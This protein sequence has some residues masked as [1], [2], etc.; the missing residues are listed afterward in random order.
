MPPLHLLL[1]TA[2]LAND[3]TSN[4][5]KCA[6]DNLG[7]IGYCENQERIPLTAVSVNEDTGVTIVSPVAETGNGMQSLDVWC[8]KNRPRLHNL[9]FSLGGVLL[10]GW[11]V[12]SVRQAEQLV[13]ESLGLATMAL[14]PE[15]FIDFN[16]RAKQLGVAPG[17]LTQTKL[18]RNA[19]LAHPGAM[20]CPHVEFGIGPHRP[21]VVVF[22]AEVPPAVGGKTARVNFPEAIKR[23]S[24]NLYH[25]L[26]EN[27]WWNPQAK[28]VQ[29]SI[30]VHPETGLETLQ[31]YTFSRKLVKVAHEAYVQVREQLRPDL[32]EVTSIPYEGPHDYS[33][34][35]VAPNGT[36]FEMPREM[37][38]EMYYAI[39]ATI[40]LQDWQ[41]GDILLFDNVLYGHFRMPGK[42]P[43]KLHAIFAEQV[44]TR[45]LR[46][47]TAP[48]CVHQAADQHANDGIQ[49]VLGDLGPGGNMF[50]LWLTMQLPDSLFQLVGKWFWVNGGGYATNAAPISRVK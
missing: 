4:T 45:T 5:D 20:Q 15:V 50:V 13:F 11:N 16:I 22:F 17:G 43:R 33:I 44:D 3:T 49:G 36:Q 10:R 32:P 40:T 9:T 38:L 2:S 6:S 25:T 31:L 28:V 26:S 18:S 27:G 34:V 42:Q 46:P 8:R 21:R 30:L 7:T 29:P 41:A 23:M 24:T 19:P 35:L 14:Y 48:A 47:A 12:S 37:Q 1:L 39:F